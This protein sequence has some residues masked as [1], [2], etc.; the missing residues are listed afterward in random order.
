MLI[1]EHR[2]R[3]GGGT[4]TTLSLLSVT[5]VND[6]L[7]ADAMGVSTPQ[8]IEQITSSPRACRATKTKPTS[9]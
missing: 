1:V 2:S 8:P 3:N 7:S 6:T 4:E 5:V 9:T